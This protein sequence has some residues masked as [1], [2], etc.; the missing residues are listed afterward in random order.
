MSEVREVLDANA[1][2]L[3]HLVLGAY[4]QRPHSWDSAFASETVRSLT[5]LDLVDTRVSQTVLSRITLATRLRALTLHGTFAN[6][7][8]AA[9]VF[10][11]DVAT[12]G[13]EHTLLPLLESIR[14][15]AVG[16]DGDADLWR[17]VL[18]FVR[19]RTRLRRLDLGGGGCPWDLVLSILPGLTGLRVLRVR[20]PSVSEAVVC[21]LVG[22]LPREMVAIHVSTVVWDR[23]LV[24]LSFT[25]TRF[26]YSLAST[27]RAP[28][29]LRNLAA[30]ACSPLCA[31]PLPCYAAPEWVCLPPAPATSRTRACALGRAVRLMGGRRAAHR[32]GVA[33]A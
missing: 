3:T 22:A 1:H 19:G 11:S 24:R 10:A 2:T 33:V 27:N 20:I 9:A 5:R 17:A 8:A 18:Q 29:G 15:V 7:A 32:R 13:G 4:L 30:R 14:F 21:A 23:P 16:H 12:L 25:P 31:L 6:P 28:V 26:S